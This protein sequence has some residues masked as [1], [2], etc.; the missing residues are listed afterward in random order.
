MGMSMPFGYFGY[1]GEQ[2]MKNGKNES[3]QEKST[4]EN[5][6]DRK[7]DEEGVAN[8]SNISSLKSKTDLPKTV[9]GRNERSKTD[10]TLKGEQVPYQTSKWSLNK[11]TKDCFRFD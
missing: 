9:L 5:R 10:S 3:N 2:Y 7:M 4:L 11:E 6:S 8:P 1:H